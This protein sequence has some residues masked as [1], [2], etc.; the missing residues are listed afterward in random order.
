MILSTRSFHHVE[1]SNYN[2][3]DILLHEGVNVLPKILIVL[4]NNAEFTLAVKKINA[5]WMRMK[6]DTYA[7]VERSVDP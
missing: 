7:R 5:V 4:D 1:T 2:Y 6:Q 3:S